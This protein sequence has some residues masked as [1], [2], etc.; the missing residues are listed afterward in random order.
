MLSAEVTLRVAI[1]AVVFLCGMTLAFMGYSFL[2]HLRSLRLTHRRDE[3]E[4]VWKSRLLDVATGG[5]W[6][7]VA[8]DGGPDHPDID[9][10]DR[11]LFL[12]L[13]TRYVRAIEGPERRNLERLGANYLD[14]L[15][16]MLEDPDAYRRAHALDILG[17][18]GYEHRQDRIAAGL[19]DESGL[20]AMVAARALARRGEPR[21]VPVLLARLEAFDS[22]S[23]RYLASLLV[24]FGPDAA[25]VL[26]EFALDSSK[27]GSLRAVV[28]QALRELNDLESVEPATRL[29]DAED[30]PE[31]QAELVRL[32]GELGTPRHLAVVRPM[33]DS[34]VP[35]VRA[36]ATRAIS[37]L[38]DG[39]PSDIEMVTRAL[40][41]ASPWVAL[42]AARGLFELGHRETLVALANSASPRADLAAEVLES[43]G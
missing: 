40:D 21:Y 1:A 22:W 31:V 38:S 34:T 17:E 32:I 29:L 39:R 13:V 18:L 2:L 36:V 14:A 9:P 28:L 15:D 41:D 4:R 8:E 10:D 12:E 24:S 25:P 26:R 7:S 3:L 5:S 11:L 23:V 6:S 27:P 35:Y 37:N 30:D 33:A 42:Q 20:V 16:E 19:N 43:H